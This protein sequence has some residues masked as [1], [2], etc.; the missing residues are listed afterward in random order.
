MLTDEE[1]KKHKKINKCEFCGVKF[2]KEN[3]RIQHHNHINGN[4]IATTCKTCNS[5]IKFDNTLYLVFHYL[6]GYDIHYIIEK[7]NVHFKDSNKIYS[8]IMHH[9][10]FISEFKI[11]SRLSTHMSLYH[12]E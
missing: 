7:V 6:K 3:R 2:D 12:I 10:F 11:I 8:V 5:K 1:M 4:Y 9:R